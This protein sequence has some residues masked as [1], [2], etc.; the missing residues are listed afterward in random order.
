LCKEQ[1]KTDEQTT[2]KN[3]IRYQQTPS[4]TN[5]TKPK[6]S[7]LT[8]FSTPSAASSG[9]L[10]VSYAASLL[11]TSSIP[12]PRLP[13]SSEYNSIFP[14][15]LASRAGVVE[16]ALNVCGRACSR[17]EEEIRE[18]ML[19]RTGN[20]A[21][22]MVRGDPAEGCRT[23]GVRQRVLKVRTK[24]AMMLRFACVYVCVCV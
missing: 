23:N 24:D 7:R 4:G 2:K 18:D 1:G 16:N 14:L 3:P 21:S 9:P 17:R 5:Q 19:G 12:A 8:S 15:S 20:E 22:S 11:A 6:R 13:D 10:L